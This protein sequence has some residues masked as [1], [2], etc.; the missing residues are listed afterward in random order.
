MNKITAFPGA[1]LILLLVFACTMPS[2]IEVTGSPSLKFAANL[3]FGDYFD[4]MLDK[5]RSSNGPSEPPMPC[6]EPSYMTFILRMEIFNQEDYRCAVD[7]SLFINIGDRGDISINGIDIPVEL[8]EAG[9]HRK[10]LVLEDDFII[11]E[12][13]IPFSMSFKGIEKYIEGF[14]FTGIKSKIYISGTDLVDILTIDIYEITNDH[15]EGIRILEDSRVSKGESGLKSLEKYTGHDL[16]QGGGEMDGEE[17][18]HTINSGGDL[19]LKCKIYI[20]EG[21]S[22]DYGLINDSHSVHAEIVIWFPMELT[23]KEENASFVFPDFFDGI[24]DV[25]KSLSGTGCIENMNINID[26]SPRNPFGNGIFVI[27]D[28]NYKPIKYPMTSDSFSFGLNKEDLDF[29]NNNPFDPKF[30]ISFPKNADLGIP[31]GD[32]MPMITTVSLDAELK[33]NMEF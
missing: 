25:F 4:D 10:F 6:T 27:N 32:T 31:N 26:I 33:Y 19:Y 9:D 15:P 29:I 17:I 1:V 24:S 14:E 20:Q 8:Q 23:A 18:S 5:V 22:I 12:S 11:A 3:N 21:T 13:D 16:P 2:E 7:E 28:D 30:F